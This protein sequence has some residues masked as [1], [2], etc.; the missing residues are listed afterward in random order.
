VQDRSGGAFADTDPW[1][2][3]TTDPNAARGNHGIFLGNGF[4][5][6]T[7]SATGGS[8]KESRAF[9]AGLYDKQE[10]IQPIPNWHDLGLP[11]PSAGA[12]EQTL[13]MKNG[14][15]TT[16]TGDTT[17]YS[18][19][20]A[21]NPHLAA[22]RVE[23]KQSPGNAPALDALAVPQ[24]VQQ[25][26]VDGESAFV[27]IV[28]IG[29][30]SKTPPTDWNTLRAA[31]ESVWQKRWE[32]ADITIEGDPEAQQLV[33]KLLFD[34]MQSAYPGGQYSIAPETLAGQ[35]YKGHIFWDAE[36]W[37]F[38]ALVALYPELARP[39]LDYRFAHLKEAQALAKQ[40]GCSGADFPWESAATGKETAPGGFSQGR[41]VTA[42]VG[43]A[44]WLY[45]QA[46]AD[47]EWINTRGW[48]LL[49]QIADYFATKAK[50][51]PAT[52]KYGIKDIT[53]PDEFDIGINNNTYTNA[54]AQKVLLSAIEASK[55]VGKPAN[56]KWAEVAKGILLPFDNENSRYL[57]FE[58]DMGKPGTKQADGELILYPANLPMK[59]ET[60]EA[61]FDFHKTRVIKNGPAMTTSIHALIAARLGRAEEAE[62]AF[63]ESYHPF[64]RGP[65]LLFSEKRSLDRCVF[66]TGAGGVLQSVIYGFGGLEYGQPDG[67]I[68]TPPALPKGWTKLTIKGVHR[69]GKRYT[70]TV[71]P[72]G[73]TLTPQS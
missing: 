37:M 8:G 38:P 58:G 61:T 48:T 71:T 31:H 65:F 5:G 69:Q 54:M 10:N 32:Q 26:E 67:L 40:Q 6:A 62:K 63:R 64:V 27:R 59:K 4:L 55:V 20:S 34:L 39:M 7:F 18:L 57:K 21:A 14:I 47:K 15:L 9:V 22:I 73:R 36:V 45:W 72:E 1:I 3:K 56:P 12:Y 33:H 66:T 25:G 70:L 53:G 52:G 49:S 19:V 28:E 17:V 35:F 2:L 46:T 43:I 60:A 51:D 29:K 23:G 24:S 42:G 68:D 41:H 30:V 11:E 50:K 13:D 16:K 44:V